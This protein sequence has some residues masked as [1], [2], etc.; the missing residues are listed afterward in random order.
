MLAYIQVAFCSP[1]KEITVEHNT[2]LLGGI[3]C[4]ALILFSVLGSFTPFIG[5][6]SLLA[7]ICLLV[8]FFQAGSQ[9]GRA[10]VKN[11]LIVSIVLSVVG[12][13]V[14]MLVAGAS[15]MTATIMDPLSGFS[16][17][18]AIVGAIIVWIIFMIA[19]WFWYKASASLAEGSNT[20]FFK[21]GGLLIFIGS[22]LLV[23]FGLGAILILIGEILQAVAF[24]N[25]PEKETGAA[26]TAA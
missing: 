12:M 14:F 23:I 18:T 15:L 21:T 20:P 11:H 19:S 4:I 22:I 9:V 13:I 17:M 8:A 7:G 6:L 25:A 1:F 24:F 26:G 3:S 16:S 5:I 2:K 10:D